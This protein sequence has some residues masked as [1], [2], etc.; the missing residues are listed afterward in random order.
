MSLTDPGPPATKELGFY[1]VY[2]L[3]AKL[4]KFFLIF[5]KFLQFR[6]LHLTNVLNNVQVS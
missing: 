1:E 4:S 6:N 5:K 3:K 2:C